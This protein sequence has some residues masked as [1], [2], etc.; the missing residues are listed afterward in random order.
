MIKFTIHFATI[1][2][3]GVKFEKD[4]IVYLQYTLLLLIPQLALH[5]H[6]FLLNLQYTLLLLI[7]RAISNKPLSDKDLQYTLLLLI[8]DATAKLKLACREFTLHFATINTS[9]RQKI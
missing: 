9:C 3:I 7:L 2:T 6:K 8:P 4:N 5:F 1:N